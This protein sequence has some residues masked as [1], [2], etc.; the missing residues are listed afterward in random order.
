MSQ[1]SL[2]LS[3]QRGDCN[4]SVLLAIQEN[5]CYPFPLQVSESPE[6]L[7]F[8]LL[9]ASSLFM[10]AWIP[11]ILLAQHCAGAEGQKLQPRAEQAPGQ[12]PALCTG[13]LPGDEDW[14]M[15]CRM[16]MDQAWSSRSG[17]GCYGPCVRSGGDRRCGIY[18]GEYLLP[19]SCVH[20]RPQDNTKVVSQVLT[21]SEIR[22]LFWTRTLLEQEQNQWEISA[23]L[24]LLY[25]CL[26]KNH[27]AIIHLSAFT[28]SSSPWVLSMDNQNKPESPSISIKIYWFDLTI[29]RQTKLLIN[30]S[31]LLYYLL[32]LL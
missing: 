26:K 9:A 1:L 31:T 6:R 8:T 21:W 32:N 10:A 24:F 14:D 5:C 15:G 17:Q 18:G 27:T 20:P 7:W 16:Q 12:P 30:S 28:W 3:K 25:I 29:L 23:L 13:H 4:C 11:S 19:A 22:N 2:L